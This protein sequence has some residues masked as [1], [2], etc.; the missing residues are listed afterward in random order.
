MYPPPKQYHIFSPD[1]PLK[2]PT[3]IVDLFTVSNLVGA[4]ATDVLCTDPTTMSPMFVSP[5]DFRTSGRRPRRADMGEDWQ[6]VAPALDARR[7]CIHTR[8]QYHG[9]RAIRVRESR[10]MLCV[11]S[12]PTYFGRHSI[13]PAHRRRSCGTHC[14]LSTLKMLVP[15]HRSDRVWTA[16]FPRLSVDDRVPFSFAAQD[17]PRFCIPKER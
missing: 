1:D 16:G 15:S 5:C 3:A 7:Y 9:S 11:V 12:T 4:V 8:F 13:L 17:S 2:S 10:A 6:I 14:F